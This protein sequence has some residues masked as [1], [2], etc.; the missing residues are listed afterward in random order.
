MAGINNLRT[1]FQPKPQGIQMAAQGGRIGYDN[2]GIMM[3]SNPSLEDSRNEMMENI[4]LDEFGKPLSDLSEDEIIQIEIMMEEMSKKSTAPRMMA[5]WKDLIDVN[6]PSFVPDSWKDLV[7]TNHSSYDKNYESLSK[8]GRAG[9]NSCGRTG[10]QR[11][12]TTVSQTLQPDYIEALGKTYAA[13][14]TRQAGIPSITQATSQMP[15]E[16]ASQFQ[17]RQ[18][19]AQQYDITNRVWV[20]L[21]HKLQHRIQC[22]Q[23]LMHKQL[24]QLMD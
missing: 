23:Q 9:Y 5:G 2:G 21:H 15:G 14:L 11:G 19:Q 17:Q 7:D 22:K 6:H 10:F 4:A 13:D 1:G 20:H 16:T 8:G 18:A 24:I 3:A 12:G